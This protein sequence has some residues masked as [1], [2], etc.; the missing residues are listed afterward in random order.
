[1]QKFQYRPKKKFGQNF[2]IDDNVANKIIRACEL[3]RSDSLIEIGP[4]LGAI[5]KKVSEKVKKLEAIE[6]DRDLCEILNRELSACKNLKVICADFLKFDL[7]ALKQE[8]KIIGNLPFYLTSPIISHIIKHKKFISSAF[9]TVQKEVAER[10][11]ASVGKKQYGS[12]S[13]FVQYYTKPMILFVIKKTCFWPR[14]EVDASFVKLEFLSKP[15]IKVKD[16]RLFFSIIRTA[17]NQRR[18]NI[19]NSLDKIIPKAKLQKSLNRLSIDSSVRPENLSLED[20]RK[21]FNIAKKGK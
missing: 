2:L 6:I 17:F 20:F 4:G 1:M 16:E 11:I 19:L 12:F 8:V 3:K 15:P 7:S 10:I 13:C 18:K 9:I 5:T 14:P 21:I